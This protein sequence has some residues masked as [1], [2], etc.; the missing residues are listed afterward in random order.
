M[1][2]EFWLGVLVSGVLFA[3]GSLISIFGSDIRL[4]YAEWQKNR[5]LHGIS[6]KIAKIERELA[7]SERLANN[8]GVAAAYFWAGT[9]QV[10]QMFL[11]FII[12]CLLIYN[13]GESRFKPYGIAAVGFL[14]LACYA[15]VSSWY[16]RAASLR[17]PLVH[18]SRLKAKLEELR[19]R[20]HK[21]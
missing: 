1:S 6:L 14:W 9:F 21:S 2:Q 7:Q 8:P 19:E 13:L 17:W 4:Y 18:M 16:E 10:L 12:S 3:I 15:M 11:L 20:L 5:S